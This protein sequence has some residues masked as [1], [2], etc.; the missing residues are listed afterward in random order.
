[1]IGASGM[2]LLD[3]NVVS[4][5]RKAKSGKASPKV[6]EWARSV[7]PASLY[8]SAITVLEIELG[9]LLIERKD[10]AQ[11]AQLRSWMSGHVLPSF[12]D[13]ILP[14]DTAV[15]LRCARLHVPDPGAER[16]MLIAATALVHGFTLVTRNMADFKGIELEV[17]NPW[18]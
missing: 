16:D 4:E 2:Y 3:T 17:L 18:G 6:I 10:A 5:L 12:A 9:I 14:V 15:A 13:R 11:G 8:L 1:M 7:P